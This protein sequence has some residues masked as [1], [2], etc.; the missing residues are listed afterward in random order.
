MGGHFRGKRGKGLIIIIRDYYY[1]GFGITWYYT[2][3]MHSVYAINFIQSNMLDVIMEDLLKNCVDGFLFF[4][5]LAQVGRQSAEAESF[6][7][8][9]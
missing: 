1:I 4:T 7:R 2:C 3:S 5:S 8:L 9:L 6:S